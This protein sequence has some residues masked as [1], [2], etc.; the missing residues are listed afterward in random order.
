[1][2][3]EKEEENREKNENGSDAER[4]SIPERR[5]NRERKMLSMTARY[6]A[7]ETSSFIYTGVLFHSK[8]S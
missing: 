2:E 5:I 6:V 1:M 3:K 8:F 4:G 7:G